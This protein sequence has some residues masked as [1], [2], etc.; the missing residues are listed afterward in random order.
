[1]R[2]F[3]RFGCWA[4]AVLAMV[5]EANAQVPKQAATTS[6]DAGKTVVVRP[7]NP[8]QVL[9][10]VNGE[11]ITKAEF[12]DLVKRYELPTNDLEQ[13]Y[14]DGLETL[15]NVKLLNQFLARQRLP[16][17]QDKID[18]DLA[19]IEKG[20]KEQGSDLA[21]ALIQSGN[22]MEDVRKQLAFRQQWLAFVTIRATDAE[23][24]KF[25]AANQDL[26]DGT[27][28]RASHIML[29]LGENATPAEKEKARQRLLAIKRDIESN[30]YKFAEAANKFSQEENKTEGDGGDIGYFAR[31][32]GILEQF[33]VPAF[34]LKVG[35]ISEPVE[36]MHGYH[37]ILV[38]DRKPGTPFKLE[39][40]KPLAKSV[41]SAELQ[42]SIVQA[43][44]KAAK[45]EIK[46]AP[47]DLF[48]TIETTP[49]A[50]GSNG[51][52]AAAPSKP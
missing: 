14:N 32:Q 29:K 37:L 38:T 40:Q 10:T 41:Y 46:P 35:Q 16:V 33:E 20:L 42:K 50:K 44:R 25:V 5:T 3:V 43:A 27:Q 2:V 36:T 34:K 18:A 45:V 26:L 31:N 15:I 11:N 52:K 8:T 28:I 12:L 24:K 9:A 23:L 4:V 21:S 48:E 19:N 30:K 6:P 7:T 51:G 47:A 13:V 39:A 17:A 49:N 1:M 22:T